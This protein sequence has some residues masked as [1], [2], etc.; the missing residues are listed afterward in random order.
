MAQHDE[1]IREFLIENADSLDVLDRDLLALEG[2]SGAPELVS[3]VFRAL[4][5]IKGTAA[6]LGFSQMEALSH[7]GESTL[8]RVRDRSLELTSEIIT[9][10]L[11]TGTELRLQLENIER[12]GEELPPARSARSTSDAAPSQPPSS[13]GRATPPS[14]ASTRIAQV[15]EAAKAEHAP[16]PFLSLT[17]IPGGASLAAIP[18]A[19]AAVPAMPALP[20]TQPPGATSEDSGDGGPARVADTSVR[21]DVALLDK[22]MN[23][24]GE[25]VLTRNQILQFAAKQDDSSM[26]TSA[27]HLNLVTT[28]LQESVMKTRMQPIGHVWSKFPRILRDLSQS[29]G[30]KVALVLEGQ[31]TELDRTIIEAIKD[32]LTHI[33]RNSVDHGI[34]SPERRRAS[35]KPEQGTLRLRAYHEGGQV[36]IEI[37]DDGAGISADRVRAKAVQKGLITLD[38]AARMTERELIELVF[39][40]GFSTAEAVTNVSGRGVGMDVVKTNIEKIGGTIDITSRVG[41]GTTLKIKIPLTLAI[42]PALVVATGGHRYAIPQVSLVELVRLEGELANLERIHGSP[43]YRLRGNLLPIVYLH[44]TLG[45]SSSRHDEDALHIVVL[46]AGD[47]SFGLVV[48]AIH[49]TE[50]IVVKPLSKVLKRAATYAGATIMGDGRVALILDAMGLAQ[51]SHVLSAASD[52]AKADHGNKAAAAETK[53][54]LLLF[55]VRGQSRMALPLAEVARLEEFAPSAVER[56]GDA[57]VVQYRGEIMPLVFVGDAVLDRRKGSRRSG[58]AVKGPAR[59]RRGSSRRTGEEASADHGADEDAKLQVIVH[60]ALGSPVGLVVDRIVDIVEEAITVQERQTRPGT[61]GAA[62]VQGRVTEFLDVAALMALVRG[63][64][65]SIETNSSSARSGRAGR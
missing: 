23:L 20:V 22:L 29:L 52:R 54:P 2:G 33:V 21:V 36:V 10:L 13:R 24:V 4:H 59:E 38:R 14:N 32:P 47:T 64:E 37:A 65:G 55:S 11:A 62:V 26:A 45:V 58:T 17:G 43:V 61:R 63:D 28:E 30:K 16:A 50:E 34:E 35:G 44:E 6:C 1:I 53:V 8:A 18:S 15:V 42:I 19:F 39:Q 3:S 40:P 48:D 9:E 7:R 46:Q 56:A 27:Q 12:N 5:S 41:A 60:T 57:A 31:E 51:R 25:L 49:D